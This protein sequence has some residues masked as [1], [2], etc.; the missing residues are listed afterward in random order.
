MLAE[1]HQWND[2]PTEDQVSLLCRLAAGHLGL[3]TTALRWIASQFECE[4]S[5]RRDK[6]I[7]EVSQLGVGELDG[8]YAFILDCILPLEDSARKRY[9]KGLKTVLGCLVVFQQPLDIGPISTLLSPDNFDVI[10][11]A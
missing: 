5:A 4:G 11:T 2:W 1:F 9:L 7:E 3:A 6:V 10:Y 8:L